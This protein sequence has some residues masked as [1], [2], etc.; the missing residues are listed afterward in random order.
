MSSDLRLSLDSQG[1]RLHSA[2]IP[3]PPNTSQPFHPRSLQGEFSPTSSPCAQAIQRCTGW[4]PPNL[5]CAPT[6]APAYT[7]H[8]PGTPENLHPHS[9]VHPPSLFHSTELA[10]KSS[11]WW[12]SSDT[13]AYSNMRGGGN[14]DRSV[15]RAETLCLLYKTTEKPCLKS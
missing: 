3:H 13:I 7:L 1:L 4:C 15:C 8:L 2:Y 14:R 11:F 5:E 12:G 10:Q 9:P 6:P